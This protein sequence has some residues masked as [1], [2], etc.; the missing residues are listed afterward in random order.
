MR[1]YIGQLL[2]IE[3]FNT[4]DLFV[5]DV[6]LRACDCLGSLVDILFLQKSL[7]K[8]S[9]Q[10]IGS[11]SGRSLFLTEHVEKLLQFIK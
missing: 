4:V 1:R 9:L 10:L 8:C 11:G 5:L 2:F 7:T 3:V 6:L